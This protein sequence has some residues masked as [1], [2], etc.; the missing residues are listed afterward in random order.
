MLSP[1]QGDSER[2]STPALLAAEPSPLLQRADAAAAV[3]SRDAVAPTLVCRLLQAVLYI[4]QHP[5]GD[6]GD[7]LR[8]LLVT[9]SSS[10]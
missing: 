8:L 2:A 7:R 4:F 1:H 10:H 6:A 9:V 3:L 5:Y